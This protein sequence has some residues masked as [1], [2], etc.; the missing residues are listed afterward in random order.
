M[1]VTRIVIK[2]KISILIFQTISHHPNNISHNMRVP[3]RFVTRNIKHLLFDFD[4]KLHLPSLI[5]EAQIAYS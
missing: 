5:L 2:L 4:S 1:S 3:I